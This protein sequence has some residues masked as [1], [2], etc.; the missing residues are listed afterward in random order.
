MVLRKQ[1]AS[2]QHRSAWWRQTTQRRGIS[3]IKRRERINAAAEK[4]R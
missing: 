1:S 3:E 2:R 4:R